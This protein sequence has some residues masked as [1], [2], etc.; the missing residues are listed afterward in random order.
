MI[1]TIS[2][3]LVAIGNS[4]ELTLLLKSTLAVALGLTIAWLARSARASLRHLVLLAT[5]VALVALPIAM[6]LV[7]PVGFEVQSASPI[8]SSVVSTTSQVQAVT[9][10]PQAASE[11]VS[12]A[13]SSVIS[14]S[15]RWFGFSIWGIGIVLFLMS[16]GIGL[17]K[18]GRLRR[19]GLPWRESEDLL[20]NLAESAG[21]RRQVDVLTHD[22]LT[23]PVTC[24]MLHPAILLPSDAKTWS[25]LDLQRVFVHELEHVKRF[26]WLTHISTRAICSFYWFHPLVW[27]ASRQIS[28]EAERACDDA[29]VVQ[30]EREDYADQLVALAR[31][32]SNALP[33]PI[34][35]MANRSDLSSRV[36]AILDLHQSRGRTG[37]V[38]TFAGLFVAVAITLGIAPVRAIGRPDN[39]QQQVTTQTRRSIPSPQQSAL[40][41]ALLKAA[42]KGKLAEITALLDAGADV[43]AALDGDGSPLIVAA[44]AG[45]IKAVMLLLGRGA[46]P[47]MGVEGDGNPIIAAAGEGHEDVVKLLLD[48]GANI[49]MVVAGDENALI[50]ASGSG[51]LN[52]VKLLV[53]RG[54]NFNAR[55]WVDLNYGGQR[56]GEWRTPLSEARKGRQTAVIEFL[57]SAGA[58]D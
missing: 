1:R 49:D 51:H 55:V 52:V 28:L 26:D 41:E 37:V 13:N 46:D 38:V 12:S 8:A 15:P 34:L 25:E 27:I 22:G 5:F 18:L 44:G 10:A 42:K 58:R 21:I 32:L 39:P 40:D 24:G 57:I 3:T 33:P 6:M 20:H 7:P 16:F 11:S 31:R 56:T 47:N 48:R 45:E 43:N 50:Q 36:S 19:S 53:S 17:W 29:V 35:S 4:T 2:E 9:T 54:A 14:L 30:T 23:V